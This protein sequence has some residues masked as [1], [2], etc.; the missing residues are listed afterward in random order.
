MKFSLPTGA[1][2]F[3]PLSLRN[4]ILPALN[5]RTAEVMSVVTVPERGEGIRPRGPSTRPSGPTTPIMSGV[6]RATS[7]SMNPPLIRCGQVVAADDVGPGGRRLLGVVALGEDRHADA[8][9]DAVRQGHRAADVLVALPGVDPEVRRDLDRL[10]E[11]RR[12]ER[13]QLLD[14]VGQGDRVGRLTFSR[15][16]R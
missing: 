15:R 13:L 3:P 12:A 14:R 6:A 2:T 10:V 8:L 11:L 9:A 16:A 1:A 5:S 7:K 4:S